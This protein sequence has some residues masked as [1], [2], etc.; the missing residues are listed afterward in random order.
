MAAGT[1]GVCLRAPKSSATITG[2]AGGTSHFL[3]LPQNIVILI[4]RLLKGLGAFLEDFLCCQDVCGEG[5]GAAL[6][7]RG[8]HQ[9]PCKC[10]RCS[11][12]SGGKGNW[13]WGKLERL[14]WLGNVSLQC[15]DQ[16]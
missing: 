1:A 9:C 7:V 15:K 10:G 8:S 5:M 13:S 6:G 2:D 4:L 12:E 16:K 11:G 3:I 14:L